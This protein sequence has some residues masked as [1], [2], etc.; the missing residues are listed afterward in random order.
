M[1]ALLG[2]LGALVSRKRQL[3]DEVVDRALGAD[4]ELD[5]RRTGG[6]RR[7]RLGDCGRGGADEAALR[8]HVE[9][10]RPLADEVRRG[11]EAG[12]PADA[13]AREEP[14][15][16]LAD[17]P[18]GGFGG[19]ARVGVLGA[20]QHQAAF[21][22]LVQRRDDERKRRLGD[23]G[24]RLRQRV[25]ERLQA[26]VLEQLAN[27]GVED[28]TVHDERRNQRF[29]GREVYRRAPPPQPPPWGPPRPP[30]V[31]LS[32]GRER[33]GA[34]FVPGCPPRVGCP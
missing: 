16:L 22:P 10:P 14:D 15:P 7:H 32:V 1:P 25:G 3:L 21:K 9:R 2:A 26:V 23:P 4:L 13:A 6:G 19:V 34:D 29:R 12:F 5:R 30:V 27:E 20:E 8:E 11:L 31:T 17:E 24:A 33:A 28:R 18:C